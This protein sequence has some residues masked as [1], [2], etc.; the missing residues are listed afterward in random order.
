MLF[1]NILFTSVVALLSGTVAAEDVSDGGAPK[2]NVGSLNLPK[3]NAPNGLRARSL[4]LLENLESL[5]LVGSSTPTA[6]PA[7]SSSSFS[8]IAQPSPTWAPRRQK[9]NVELLSEVGSI[10]PG[11]QPTSSTAASSAMPSDGYS[12]HWRP[13]Q[14]SK[15]WERRIVATPISIPSSVPI[16]SARMSPTSTPRPSM[17]RVK[18]A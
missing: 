6:T 9:R 11:I 15:S 18:S 8:H 3:R 5:V 12:H 7:S 16:Q 1:K 17:K 2:L 13:N 14:P 10:I 4:T